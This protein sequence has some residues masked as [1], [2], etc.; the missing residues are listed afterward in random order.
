MKKPTNRDRWRTGCPPLRVSA[1]G[2]ALLTLAACSTPSSAPTISPTQDR[3][4]V[5]PI[6]SDYK[7][8]EH[9]V[10]VGGQTR[11]Y[12]L[13]APDALEPGVVYPVLIAYH[14]G[15]GNPNAMERLSGLSEL[16]ERERI[17]LVYPYGSS[18]RDERRLTFNAGSCCA[19]AQITNIDDVGFTDA[20]IDDLV[21]SFQADPRRIFLTGMSNGGLM[22]HRYAAERSDRVA[23]IAPVG[24]PLGVN[25]PG[26]TQPVAVMHIHGTADELAPFHGG[27]GRNGN[28]NPDR[29]PF[30]SAGDTIEAWRVA[31]GC[32]SDANS[33]QLPDTANDGMTT[34]LL[35]MGDCDGGV[36]VVLVKVDGGGHTWPGR[37]PPIDLLGA[38]TMD[39]SANDLMWSFFQ[40][41]ARTKESTGADLVRTRSTPTSFLRIAL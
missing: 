35:R 24:G 21:A 31:N 32:G 23:A 7:A 3:D 5:E 2:V 10:D 36:E 39:F 19:F 14:G 15:G 29:A 9:S 38:S 28:R 40:R 11:Q 17:L 27:L 41:H 37:E 12:R 18:A 1:L 22:A 25:I 33:E 20:V 13:F 4:A 30:R 26:L 16:A 34:Q 8:Q 6:N